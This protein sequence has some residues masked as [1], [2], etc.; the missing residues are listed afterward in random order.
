MSNNDKGPALASKRE[1]NGDFSSR[2]MRCRASNKLLKC[3]SGERYTR[4]RP[5]LEPTRP[6]PTQTKVHEIEDPRDQEAKDQMEACVQELTESIHEL[7]DS[8]EATAVNG[9]TLLGEQD[10]ISN[11]LKLLSRVL[12]QL[13]KTDLLIQEFSS[14]NSC[15][16]ERVSTRAVKLLFR[17]LKA[18]QNMRPMLAFGRNGLGRATE[19]PLQESSGKDLIQCLAQLDQTTHDL[20]LKWQPTL[21]ARRVDQDDVFCPC[22]DIVESI[23]ECLGFWTTLCGRMIS[24]ACAT[25]D[26]LIAMIDI[27]TWLVNCRISVGI[28]H[29]PMPV[30]TQL[31]VNQLCLCQKVLLDSLDSLNSLI[32]KCNIVPPTATIARV[33]K[34]MHLLHQ[35]QF[36][37][38]LD[39]VRQSS[40][41]SLSRKF[42]AT[43]KFHMKWSSTDHPLFLWSTMAR[44]V[45]YTN[46]APTIQAEGRSLLVLHRLRDISVGALN[47]TS[48][49]FRSHACNS[50][51]EGDR[52]SITAAKALIAILFNSVGC[53][54]HE[55]NTHMGPVL[56]AVFLSAQDLEVSRITV[57]GLHHIWQ[58]SDGVLPLI[59]YVSTQPQHE[60]SSQQRLVS[61]LVAIV[62][63]PTRLNCELEMVAQRRLE[64]I[65]LIFAIMRHGLDLDP[66]KE[67]ELK[68][69]PEKAGLK[70]ES[71][72]TQEWAQILISIL[73]LK[74]E[75]TFCAVVRQ[76]RDLDC[77]LSV[78]LIL[79]GPGIL[80][81]VGVVLRS[82]LS[83]AST[84]GEILSFLRDLLSSG[85]SGEP[86]FSVESSQALQPSYSEEL[87]SMLARTP[88]LLEGITLCARTANH[89]ADAV[90]GRMQATQLNRDQLEGLGLLAISILLSVSLEALNR[91]VL[92][93]QTGVVPTLICFLRQ[94]QHER[95][96]SQVADPPA[97]ADP[98]RGPQEQLEYPARDSENADPV[99]DIGQAGYHFPL[100]KLR[101][102]IEF[103][104]QAM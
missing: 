8:P 43:Q 28:M 62:L 92:A 59:T 25:V 53:S 51:S 56:V 91:R 34:T 68:T 3:G 39:N 90:A 77:V 86:L 89:G 13:Q 79:A 61:R 54:S 93:R 19:L 73:C 16:D 81:S 17:V 49:V 103:L 101:S 95:L 98:A 84:K 100:P 14:K 60:K 102:Q 40:A 45:E 5:T 10:S 32:I 67:I 46:A 80:Q 65:Q 24:E 104:L 82:E 12:H 47:S 76:I 85:K 18:G 66:S 6:A 33:K 11:V 74:E 38:D 48:N 96:V 99:Q 63:S 42:T 75:E 35:G 2:V 37:G 26:G 52:N 15:P 69:I 55:L 44:D 41:F 71:I 70:R 72:T 30:T 22:P 97:F 31:A 88:V 29:A 20:L 23:V 83:S 94:Q 64:A 36:D 57:Q 4:H 9:I 50:T 27:I 58:S 87:R 1:S 78:K 21:P 7:I